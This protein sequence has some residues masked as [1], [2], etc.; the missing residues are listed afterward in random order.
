L[1]KKTVL[2]TSEKS[3]VTNRCLL[4]SDFW[5]KKIGTLYNRKTVGMVQA[6]IGNDATRTANP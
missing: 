2:V 4:L 1:K 3:Y 6:Y 5:Q